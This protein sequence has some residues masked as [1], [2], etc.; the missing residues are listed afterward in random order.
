MTD[1]QSLLRAFEDK[2]LRYLIVG[3]VAVNLH[4][5][6]RFTHDIDILLA[7]DHDNLATMAQIMESFGYHQRLP[8]SIQ[9]L[10]DMD[11][12]RILMKEKGLVAYSFIH[13]SEPQ[14]NI[15]VL[16]GESMEFEK[17]TAHTMHAHVWGLDVPV[18]SID[19]LIAM[20]KYSDREKDIQDVVALL[21]LKGL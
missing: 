5:Y 12:V 3:G 10:E 9:E 20:K 17:F 2:K 18:V 7:L 15:D 16:V 13:A 8:V 19:D 21:E 4:G 11:K 1:Y 14:F 6:P